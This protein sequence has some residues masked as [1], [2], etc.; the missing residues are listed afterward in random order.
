MMRRG[1]TLVEIMVSLAIT[2]M[3]LLALNVFVFSMGELW[4]R[5]S[6][7]HLFDEH[8]NAVTQF[9]QHEIDAATF[10]PAARANATPVA[11]TQ[12]TPMNG[13]QDNLIT[14]D[15]LS[16]GRFFTWPDRPLPEVTCSF[17]VRAHEGLF[18]LWHSRLEVNYAN[19]PPRETRVSPYV[20]A[21]SFDYYD[22]SENRWSTSTLLQT[23]SGGNPTTPQRLRLTFTYGK[24]TRMV[25]INVPGGVQGLP[26]F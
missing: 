14:F 26:N 24:M 17:Q 20:T 12:I 7:R 15:L 5:G 10:P 3:L 11:P 8:V 9:L 13:M 21:L 18:L 19:Q 16:G 6:Q 4:G 22:T 1:F 23:D 25:L 2:A